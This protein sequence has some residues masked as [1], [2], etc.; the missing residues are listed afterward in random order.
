MNAKEPDTRKVIEQLY[1]DL[2]KAGFRQKIAENKAGQRITFGD[3]LKVLNDPVYHRFE[4]S[5]LKVKLRMLRNSVVPKEFVTVY[6]F[7]KPK[8]TPTCSSGV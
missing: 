4:K 2:N 8:K 3:I 7:K 1:P 5:N 6:D